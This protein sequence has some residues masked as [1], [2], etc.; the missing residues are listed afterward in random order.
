MS[1]YDDLQRSHRVTHAG[2]VGSCS[3]GWVDDA[4]GLG[5]LRAE[6]DELRGL[7][8]EAMERLNS[9]CDDIEGGGN[10]VCPH[11]DDLCAVDSGAPCGT[12]LSCKARTILGAF[13]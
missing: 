13:P 3:C 6:R 4:L 9:D 2:M 1:D 8:V 10:V 7:L 11:C 12:C 5:A